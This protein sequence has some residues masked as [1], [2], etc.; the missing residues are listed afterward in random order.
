VESRPALAGARVT[1]SPEVFRLMRRGSPEFN[2]ERESPVE[3][4]TP[5]LSM[6]ISTGSN[7]LRSMASYTFFA[8][9]SETSCSADLPPK[10]MPTVSLLLTA[11]FD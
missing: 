1:G 6:P 2:N 4:Q 9:W 5:F 7:L 11:N 10:M 3:R 8:D